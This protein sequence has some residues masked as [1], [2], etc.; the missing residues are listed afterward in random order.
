[1]IHAAEP[2][3]TETSQDKLPGSQ[4]E[5]TKELTE[6]LTKA[7]S[8]SQTELAILAAVEKGLGIDAINAVYEQCKLVNITLSDISV[9]FV[10]NQ[11]AAGADLD[12]AGADSTATAQT[13]NDTTDTAKTGLDS[14][15]ASKSN[16]LATAPTKTSSAGSRA[17]RI[18]CP[19]GMKSTVLTAGGSTT[20][21]SQTIPT[22]CT[23]LSHTGSTYN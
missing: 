3:L 17:T 9:P 14:T 21:G 2:D 5:A 22:G 6:A 1:M 13:S 23:D 18:T 20:S 7:K 11:A 15:L 8:V 16:D 19:L 4:D 10:L 12:S